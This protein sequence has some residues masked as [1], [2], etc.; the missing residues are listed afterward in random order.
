MLHYEVLGLHY[1]THLLIDFNKMRFEF[2]LLNESE[3]QTKEV[4]NSVSNTG[5]K[6]ELPSF[7]DGYKCRQC[8]YEKFF[9]FLTAVFH[10]S[11]NEYRNIGQDGFFQRALCRNR[12]SFEKASCYLF[13]IIINEFTLKNVYCKII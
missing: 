1:E 4:V 2:Q 13:E 6:L 12:Q 8:I 3:M 7:E 5:F 10:N 9:L 11:F